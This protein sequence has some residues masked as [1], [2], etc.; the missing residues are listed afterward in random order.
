MKNWY[1]IK[2]QA[3]SDQPTEVFIYDEIGGWG[4]TAAQFVRD[5]KALG[6]RPLNIRINRPAGRCSM[7]WQ[8]TTTCPPVPT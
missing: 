8:F 6:D 3:Q 7:V 2:A 5:M 1:E 4:V